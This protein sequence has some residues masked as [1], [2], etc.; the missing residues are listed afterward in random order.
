MIDETA[1]PQDR[2]KDN[3]IYMPLALALNISPLFLLSE[4]S[5][6]YKTKTTLPHI[7]AVGDDGGHHSIRLTF[8]HISLV[9]LWVMPINLNISSSWRTAFGTPSCKYLL[10]QV[11]TLSW[12]PCAHFGGTPE[13]VQQRTE[14]EHILLAWFSRLSATL[15][16][17]PSILTYCFST[18][19]EFEPL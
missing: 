6:S 13:S 12:T 15:R 2:F 18:I 19:V 4:P 9:Q 11:L 16:F 17:R 5:T 7:F 14:D 1:I 8:F 3:I 10:D